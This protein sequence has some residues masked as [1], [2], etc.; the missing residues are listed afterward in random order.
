MREALI[1]GLLGGGL[2]VAGIV[3]YLHRRRQQVRAQYRHKLEAALADGTLTSDEL[4]E[5][6]KFRESSDLSHAEVRMIARAIYRS[7]LRQAL[8][9]ARLMEQEDQALRKLQL[10]LALSES[11]L[12]DEGDAV[13]RLRL[14][15]RIQSDE[16]PV[17]EAPIHLVPNEIAHWV[18]QASLAERLELP[19]RGRTAPA[20]VPLIV[21]SEAGFSA[22]GT[23]TELRSSE[24]VLPVDLGVL[25]VTSRRTVFHGVKRTVSVPHARL[26]RI[27]LYADGLRFEEAGGAARGDFLVDDAELTAAVAL[28]AARK[29]RAEIKPTRSGRTA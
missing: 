24:E 21:T 27:V 1:I 20:G 25:V 2:A 9:D 6:E 4:A 29:R 12:G 22:E 7:A 11:D 10:Q 16:L 18:V 13:A 26:D 5:L 23:R 8:D 28:Q 15:A 19:G 3:W 17:V 14:L